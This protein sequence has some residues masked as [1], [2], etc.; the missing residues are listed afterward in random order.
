MFVKIGDLILNLNNIVSIKI[1]YYKIY[2]RTVNS[3]YEDYDLT[4]KFEDRDEL[5]SFINR[6][7]N[8]FNIYVFK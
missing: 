8:D 1:D 5:K 7:L 3:P 4:I 6:L 2:I